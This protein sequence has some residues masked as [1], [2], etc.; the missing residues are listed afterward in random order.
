MT[1]GH[2]TD[3]A[4]LPR[5]ALS[6]AGRP[7]RTLAVRGTTTIGRDDDNDI[8]LDSITVSRCH[9]VLL[10]DADGVQLV[11][12]ASTNGTAVNGVPVSPDEPLSLA[13]GDIIQLGHVLAR[14]SAAPADGATRAWPNGCE[15]SPGGVAD[16]TRCNR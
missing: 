13:D 5:L 10:R 4:A 6:E 2:T 16:A 14:Y 1:H 15:A 11:D 7:D 9:A 8:V 3:S 12:L